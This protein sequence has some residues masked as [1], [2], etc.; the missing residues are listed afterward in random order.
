MSLAKTAESAERMIS[1]VW[2]TLAA[3]VPPV[4]FGLRLWASVS[5]ALYVAFWLQL[6]NACWAGT[7]A[8]PVCQPRL[9]ALERFHHDWKRSSLFSRAISSA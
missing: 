4:V 1:E 8:A 7:S 3:W 6:D 5:L 2:V 9:G